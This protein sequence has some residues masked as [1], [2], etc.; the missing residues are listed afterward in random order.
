MSLEMLSASDAPR[1]LEDLE[2]FLTE[3]GVNLDDDAFE[4]E[5]NSYGWRVVGE[6]R[7]KTAILLWI[8]CAVECDESIPRNLTVASDDGRI[9][10][11]VALMRALERV[12]DYGFLHED[13]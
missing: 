11:D 6:R 9:D 7:T 12:L 1:S 2:A 3:H 10:R 8:E 5:L 4:L 13:H